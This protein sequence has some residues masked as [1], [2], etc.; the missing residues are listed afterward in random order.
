MIKRQEKAGFRRK[1]VIMGCQNRPDGRFSAPKPGNDAANGGFHARMGQ[2][3][4]RR[5]N[6]ARLRHG[7]GAA[8]GERR[9]GRLRRMSVSGFP[10]GLPD[11]N[12][13]KPLATALWPSEGRN[14]RHARGMGAGPVSDRAGQ[15][16]ALC[17]PCR[18]PAYFDGRRKQ[19]GQGNKP[20]LSCPAD[21]AAFGAFASTRK[22]S[23]R[24]SRPRAGA[25]GRNGRTRCRGTRTGFMCS[26]RSNA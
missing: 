4:E 10:R 6:R 13:H 3:A 7:G 18:R 9:G 8:G 25:G 23:W 11:G 19:G 21:V 20:D 24:Q 22:A 16:R 14:L 26:T 12:P 5:Q 15:P 1:P 2:M 17:R